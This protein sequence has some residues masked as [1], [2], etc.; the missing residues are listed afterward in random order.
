[1]KTRSCICSKIYK[2]HPINKRNVYLALSSQCLFRSDCLPF[3]SFSFSH[4]LFCLR[5]WPSSPP[6]NPCF[7]IPNPACSAHN[8]YGS[9]VTCRPESSNNSNPL[10][11]VTL[12]QPE[13]LLS[14]HNHDHDNL[15]F[16]F[17]NLAG[18]SIGE[19]IPSIRTDWCAILHGGPSHAGKRSV[20]WWNVLGLWRTSLVSCLGLKR[21]TLCGLK[22]SSQTEASIVFVALS[23]SNPLRTLLSQQTLC[24]IKCSSRKESSILLF[25]VLSEA[26]CPRS[27]PASEMVFLRFPFHLSIVVQRLNESICLPA[28]IAFLLLGL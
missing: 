27:S 5:V 20:L 18:G 6:Q 7:P 14:N 11:E 12:P 16:Q 13:P 2:Y 26:F 17:R 25:V 8:G 3:Q 9:F 23:N 19:S 15:I 24:G 22:C 21:K 28:L 1:M 10:P 4:A